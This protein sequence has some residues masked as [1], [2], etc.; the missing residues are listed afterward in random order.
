[1]NILKR[2]NEEKEN[3]T[4]TLDKTLVKNLKELRRKKKLKKIS[5]LINELLWLWLES[6][7]QDGVIKM[8]ITTRGGARLI[9]NTEETA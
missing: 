8:N 9:K 1:M 6:E 3:V 2:I 7:D 4:I 5:P